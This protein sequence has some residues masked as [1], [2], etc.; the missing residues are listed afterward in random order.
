MSEM[1]DKVAEAIGDGSIWY[2]AGKPECSPLKQAIM[3]ADRVR[4][5]RAIAAMREPTD[6]MVRFAPY[7]VIYNSHGEGIDPDPRTTWTRMTDT[8]LK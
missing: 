6:E 2:W 4:A 8:A 5:R 7:P 3:D 1:V